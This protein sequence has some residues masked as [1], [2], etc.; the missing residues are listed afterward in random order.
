[1]SHGDR[2]FFA[3]YESEEH[4]PEMYYHVDLLG[5][6]IT[7]TADISESTCSCNAAVYTV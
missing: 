6:K 4:D 5:K 3:N 1:M 2:L 7:Y